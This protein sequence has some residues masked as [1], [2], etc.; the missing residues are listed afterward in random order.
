MLEGVD[1]R[2]EAFEPRLGPIYV[3]GTGADASTQGAEL[4]AHQG[5]QP[6]ARLRAP[7]ARPTGARRRSPQAPGGRLEPPDQQDHRPSGS[8]P[9]PSTASA[10]Y[11][12]LDPGPDHLHADHRAPPPCGS[13]P[14]A[15]SSRRSRARRVPDDGLRRRPRTV[16][17]ADRGHRPR[18]L[19]RRLPR[20]E[21]GAAAA[22]W[23]TP[24]SGPASGP[25]RSSSSSS[26]ARS[27]RCRARRPS[28]SASTSASCRPSCCAT[29]RRRP[30][31]TSSGPAG[32]VDE[33]TPPHSCSPT[34]SAAR[35]TCPGSP[36]PNRMIAGEVRAPYVPLEQRADRPP[37]RPL[38]RA[39]GVLPAPVSY[40][41]HGVAESGGV[42][43]G[44]R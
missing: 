28:N 35:T 34:P 43:P 12:R 26:A 3:R 27:T 38:R 42:P 37:A 29:C 11:T 10:R 19:P 41:R 39:R 23:S 7:T 33:P 25:P 6:P 8:S 2:D 31:T 40:P 13:A 44:R 9:A 14:G 5:S 4:A 20:H 22:S 32:P 24:R 21:P 36:N 18:P 16:D 1:P 30:P 17:A 15:A